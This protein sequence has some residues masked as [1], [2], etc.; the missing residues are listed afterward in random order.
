MIP[1]SEQHLRKTLRSWS[2]HYN[3]GRPHSSLGLGL[4]EPS[5]N[6]PV[7]WQRQRHR[8]NRPGRVVAHPVLKGLHHDYSFLARAA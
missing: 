4:P 6:L 2:A 3:R 7:P 8:F 1:L 5:L